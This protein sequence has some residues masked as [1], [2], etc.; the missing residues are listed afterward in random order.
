MRRA[1][2]LLALLMCMVPGKT[3]TQFSTEMS[4]GLITE[5]T[6][7]LTVE[8]SGHWLNQGILLPDSSTLLLFGPFMQSLR[9]DAGAFY[10]VTVNKSS[11]DVILS[12]A[13]NL[14]S[15]V[16][17]LLSQ[18]V[19]L[20]NYVITLDADARLSETPGNTVKGSSGHIATSRVL[21]MPAGENIAGLGLQITSGNDL[22]LTELRRGHAAQSANG[23]ESILRYFDVWPEFSLGTE[24][25][26]IP[27]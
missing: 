1:G 24:A 23:Q 6:G 4:S 13:V 12:G 7:A 5:C 3:L 9:Q 19:V 16:L 15:G 27:V 14:N 2:F 18:D 26:S 10:N 8:T 22:G 11:G 25:Y 17:S 21:S 20:N